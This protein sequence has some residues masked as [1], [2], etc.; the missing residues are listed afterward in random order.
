MV[1][2]MPTLPIEVMRICSVP[3]SVFVVAPVKNTTCVAAENPPAPPPRLAMLSVLVVAA[4]TAAKLRLAVKKGGTAN[5]FS[6]TC[7]LFFWCLQFQNPTLLYYLKFQ[8]RWPGLPL[9]CRLCR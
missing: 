8:V 6:L 1:V 5:R 3:V 2:P 7:F 4:A 9:E